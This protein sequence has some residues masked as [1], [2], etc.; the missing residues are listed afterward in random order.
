VLFQ[1]LKYVVSDELHAYLRRDIGPSLEGLGFR[2]RCIENPV[3]PCCPFLI[4]ERWETEW[5]ERIEHLIEFS[6]Y[7]E[8]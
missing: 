5:E 6:A 1:N 7:R 2:W 8:S 3:A 4:A